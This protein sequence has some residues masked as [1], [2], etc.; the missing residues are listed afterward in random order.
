MKL[1]KLKLYNYRC[2]GDVRQ[3]IKIEDI[4]SFVE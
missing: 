3:T 2:F 1:S 4:T